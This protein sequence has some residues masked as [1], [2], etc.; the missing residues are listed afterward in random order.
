VRRDRIVAALTMEQAAVAVAAVLAVLLEPQ[1]RPAARNAPA[2]LRAGRSPHQKRVTR[3]LSAR[4]TIKITATGSA[5][6]EGGCLRL[7][8]PMPGDAF[9]G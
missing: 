8:R 5:C 2:A 9:E 6:R 3:R 4:T 1:D 7:K